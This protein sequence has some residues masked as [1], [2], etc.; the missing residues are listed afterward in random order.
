MAK[1][2]TPSASSKPVSAETITGPVSVYIQNSQDGKNFIIKGD[3][4]KIK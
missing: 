2:T 4:K 1:K 3:I